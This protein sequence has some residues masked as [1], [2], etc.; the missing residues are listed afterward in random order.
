MLTYNYCN[1]IIYINYNR[2]CN[3]MRNVC[4]RGS[5][6]MSNSLC[7]G[8]CGVETSAS[9]LYYVYNIMYVCM[10][11]CACMYVNVYVYQTVYVIKV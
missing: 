7:D 8:V 11:I 4:I 5:K 2:L 9:S 3:I 6:Y 10:Y 1:Y